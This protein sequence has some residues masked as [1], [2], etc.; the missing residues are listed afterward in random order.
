VLFAFLSNSDGRNELIEDGSLCLA[1]STSKLAA[2]QIQFSPTPAVA[3]E[4]LDEPHEFMRRFQ[5]SLGHWILGFRE[6]SIAVDR[7]ELKTPAE[8]SD[9]SRAAWS[10]MIAKRIAVL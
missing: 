6:I 4:V 5:D 9:A 2:A 8:R 3:G 1:L 10:R 7:S